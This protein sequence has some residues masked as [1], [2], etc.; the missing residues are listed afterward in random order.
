MYIPTSLLYSKLVGVGAQ[1]SHQTR[2]R[3]TAYLTRYPRPFLCVPVMQY[4]R[5]CGVEGVACETNTLIPGRFL[6]RMRISVVWW[7]GLV[8]VLNGP[9]A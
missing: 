1:S 7:S 8:C 9:I 2:T 3:Y 4:I 5:C 6:S